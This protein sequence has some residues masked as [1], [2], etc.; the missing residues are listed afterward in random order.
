MTRAFLVVLAFVMTACAGTVEDRT[1]TAL[2]TVAAVVDPAYDA[3]MTGCTAV[4]DA[5]VATARAQGFKEAYA[6]DYE[7]NSKRCSKTREAFETIRT[8]HT[9]AAKLV[10]SGR[11]AEAQAALARLMG[12]WRA[13][14]GAGNVQGD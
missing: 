11:F 7:A 6:S 9:E 3:A 1:R 14:R 12:A 13:L 10:E 4:G 5:I 8:L 2:N